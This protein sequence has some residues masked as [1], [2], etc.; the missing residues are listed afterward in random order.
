[1]S[2]LHI[3]L[4]SITSLSFHISGSAENKAKSAVEV[5][6]PT[7]YKESVPYSMGVY[8]LRM[9][10]TDKS[11]TCGTCWN[12]KSA[13][14]G[15]PG[16]ISLRVPVRSPLFIKDVQKWLKVICFSCGKPVAGWEKLREMERT[17]LKKSAR[18]SEYIKSISE[19]KG[20]NCA[21][22]QSP[23]PKIIKDKTDNIGIFQEYWKKQHDKFVLVE[24]EGISPALI[25]PMLI[26][27]VLNSISDE[28]TLAFGKPLASHPRN[29]VLDFLNVPPNTI[30]PDIRNMGGSKSDTNTITILLQNIIKLNEQI[31][32]PLPEILTKGIIADI[33]LLEMHVYEMI[34]GS[35]NTQKLGISNNSKQPLISLAKRLPRKVGRI[36]RNLMGRRANNMARS[37][38]TCDISLPIDYIGLP[39]YIA[40]SILF[41][42]HVQDYNY[43]EC[44]QWFIN[45]ESYPS[46]KKIKKLRTGQ[47]HNLYKETDL[48][49]E[50][51]DVIF[52]QIID[53]DIVN[54]NRQPSLEASSICSMGVRVLAEGDTIRM[55][56]SACPL[57]NADFDGDEMNIQFP[58]SSRAVNE[59]ARLSSPAQR[60]ISYKG[61]SP[62]IGQAQDAL[63]GC[64]ELTRSGVKMD[65]LHAM[66][67]FGKTSVRHDFSQYSGKAVFTGRDVISI[68]LQETGNKI[69]YSTR[70]TYYDESQ[71]AYRKYNPDEINVVIKQGKHISGMLD[72]SS[73]GQGSKNSLFHSVYHHNGADVALKLVFQMQQI[74]LMHLFNRGITVSPRDILLHPSAQIETWEIEQAIIAESRQITTQLNS[75]R[76][77]APLGKTIDEHYE[78]L[79]LAAL[80][81]GDKFWPPLLKS[82]DDEN[83]CFDKLIAYGSKGSKLNFKNISSANG[84]VELDGKRIEEKLNGRTLPFFTRYSSDPVSRG[85]IAESF[86]V[87]LNVAS[88]I[89][90]SMEVRYALIKMALSTSVTGTFNRMGVKN[91]E[92]NIIDNHRRVSKSGKIVQFLYGGDGVDPRALEKLSIP[93]CKADLNKSSIAELYKTEIKLFPNWCETDEETSKLLDSEFKQ[94]LVDRSEFIEIQLVRE[95]S[96]GGV[97]ED[98]IYTPVNLKRIIDDVK[99]F[100]SKSSKLQ[101][102][103]AI[104][105][106][107]QFCQSVGFL[108]LNESYEANGGSIP[109]HMKAS[110]HMMCIALRSWLCTTKLISYEFDNTQLDLVLQQA[111]IAFQQG[112]VSYGLAVGVIAAQSISEPLSQR[113]ISSK[114]Y[115]GISSTKTSG[116]VR[117]KELLRA[118]PTEKLIGAAMEIQLVEPHCFDEA[119]VQK[120]AN[121]IE[122]LQISR[123]VKSYQIF[124]EAFGK[125]EH[126]DFAK[127][128][129]L[130]NEFTKYTGVKVPS[131]LLHWCIRLELDKNTII[132]KNMRVESIYSTIRRKFPY[133][134]IVY[135][136]ENSEQV[137]MRIYIRS[138]FA[139]K[140]SLDV[141]AV[142]EFV[143]N[144]LKQVARGVS[145]I[146]SASVKESKQTQLQNDSSL[147]AISKYCIW[148]TGT[149]LQEI[150]SMTLVDR[151]LTKTD[152]VIENFEMFGIDAACKKT[153]FEL[154]FQVGTAA[155]ARHFSIYADE[156]S[157][158]GRLTSIDRYGSNARNSSVL[159]QIS[160]ANPI[161]IIENAAINGQTDNLAGVSAPIMI[162]KNPQIGVLFNGFC[163]DE[164]FVAANAKDLSDIF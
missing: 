14:P 145:G 40:Q 140:G 93:L 35:S 50:T 109:E 51:G 34:K 76:I 75:G 103:K 162:G 91:L 143:N 10:T 156:M 63:I 11:F 28:T 125:P 65:K 116:M 57:F 101:I 73:V 99:S 97:Y 135:T 111:S 131:D 49:L 113:V 155:V 6:V 72:K 88:V 152:S 89:L 58:R 46:C 87:G 39:L 45:R 159:L 48:M 146:I 141:S 15:H 133:T 52:R 151:R 7:L 3:P 110:T 12:T 29:L 61:S 134:F 74:S 66:R 2:K 105:K 150:M 138:I 55:N 107:S 137:V 42:V 83:N 132:E 69:D 108:L 43:Q 164:E 16:M 78:A 147:K 17:G 18:L 38:I 25:Q 118:T 126:P 144:I 142:Q 148:T 24:E 82:I 64:A 94:L 56:L 70:A 120:F 19:F 81:P 127:E 121:H 59:I 30:R 26:S 112:L 41:P 154:Q 21:H 129:G 53:D 128:S 119:I 157:Q 71:A 8:D 90:H 9:G 47:T 163:I 67:L 44:L 23:H 36:R 114:N 115:S 153:A 62:V 22:C 130:V 123:F 104:T 85:Y 60:F 54:F 149:N 96:I 68:L 80:N 98:F 136:P 27:K 79:Q 4:S 37:F 102:S 95:N 1:M 106:L 13:C 158:T 92:S 31:P 124:F 117:F 33:K 32:K 139:K 122:M 77:I 160:D 100:S 84:Q 86:A 5:K 20:L 161:S